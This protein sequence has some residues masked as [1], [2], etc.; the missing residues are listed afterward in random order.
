MS[1]ATTRRTLGLLTLPGGLTLL[2]VLLAVRAAIPL[3][4]RD[5]TSAGWMRTLRL[6]IACHWRIL[7]LVKDGCIPLGSLR[8]LAESFRGRLDFRALDRKVAE[9]NDSDKSLVVTYYRQAPDLALAHYLG[10]LFDAVVLIGPGDPGG[11]DFANLRIGPLAFRH[12][13]NRDVP[14][15]DRPDHPVVL[16]DRQHSEITVPHLFRCLADRRIGLD[17]V[18]F[19]RHNILELMH[20]VL[21]YASNCVSF[22]SARNDGFA[23][24][25]RRCGSARCGASKS[26]IGPK[27]LNSIDSGP[28]YNELNGYGPIFRRPP[29]LK[30]GLWSVPRGTGAWASPPAHRQENLSA[31]KWNTS[32]KASTELDRRSRRLPSDC[33]RLAGQA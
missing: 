16:A 19:A 27:E 6:L 31:R 3:P 4:C 20:F 18:N 21:L 22:D 10:R 13:S 1:T 2:L 7:H 12:R 15:G 28:F 25:S 14:I 29:W 30:K 33:Q 17:H 24:F 11:H 26:R 5:A 23:S 32:G 9:G 8:N